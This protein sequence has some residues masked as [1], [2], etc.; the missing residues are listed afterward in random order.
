MSNMDLTVVATA[1]KKQNTWPFN[2]TDYETKSV[3]ITVIC[4]SYKNVS[5]K[6]LFL[7]VLNL[8]SNQPSEITMKNSLRVFLTYIL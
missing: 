7:M 1:A 2:W 5:W 6:T 3:D 8:I 4:Y